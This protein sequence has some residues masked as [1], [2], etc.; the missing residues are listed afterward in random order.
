MRPVFVDTQFFI[1]LLS[2]R[3]EGHD[4]ASRWIESNPDA[5][6]VT[7]SAILLEVA[8]GMSGTGTR[9]LC[10]SFLQDL[11]S[12]GSIRVV[13]AD[14]ARFARGLDLYRQRPDKAWSLTDCISFVIMADEGI[15]AALTIDHHFEQAGFT[16]LL[17]PQS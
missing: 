4:S 9:S 8:D 11:R 6:L 5:R 1:A 3:D 10:A 2:E 15:P 17:R 14:E 7:T 13:Q 16:A 12:S